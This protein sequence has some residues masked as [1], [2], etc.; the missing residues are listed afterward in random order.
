MIADLTDFVRS[1]A[2]GEP[3]DAATYGAARELLMSELV[4]EIARRGLRDLP[5]RFLG[6][7]GSSWSA[8]LMGELVSDCYGELFVRRLEGLKNQLLVRPSINGVITRAVRNFL[9]DRQ[10]AND[11]LG[12]QLYEI[13]AA[14]IRRLEAAGALR[15]AAAAA[16]KIHNG[17]LLVVGSGPRP[18]AASAG[19]LDRLVGTWSAELW[20][21]L[22]T[23]RGPARRK[24]LAQLDGHVAS[25]AEE[26]FAEC[27]F[28]DL[29]GAL[30]NDFRG[31]WRG[32]L[33]NLAETM[34]GSSDS[35]ARLGFRQ[36][37]DCVLE[38]LG[39]ES[40]A[41]RGDLRKLWS[42]LWSYA[43]GLDTSDLAAKADRN[44]RPPSD[45]GLERELGISRHRIAGLKKTLSRLIRAC[46]SPLPADAEAG[47]P[48][49]AVH[50]SAPGGEGQMGDRQSVRQ[51]ADRNSSGRR[52]SR[53]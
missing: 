23:A 24:V 10:R 19:D 34:I 52:R 46:Q 43:A 6:L 48:V 18:A 37:H 47:A 40:A 45:L 20:P 21:H 28:G 36:L 38:R 22:V 12:F 7:P 51:A 11:P 27:L 29:V 44:G 25:L 4:Q 31:R 32:E 33:N 2:G 14:C 39:Q 50:T 15:V 42:F 26:G 13:L 8:D 16:A 53:P 17:T 9:H 49:A 41:Q 3:P 30:K 5:P 35:N 1:L